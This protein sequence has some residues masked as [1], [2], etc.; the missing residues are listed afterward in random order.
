MST[1]QETTVSSTSSRGRRGRYSRPR[2]RGG[3]VDSEE[4]PQ[5]SN[6]LPAATESILPSRSPP[7]RPGQ[8]V[9]PA[10]R[11]GETRRGVQGQLET[12]RQVASG[13]VRHN[14][15]SGRGA[16]GGRR[17]GA[18]HNVP[19]RTFGG[20]L[21]NGQPSTL[22][23]SSNPSLQPDAPEFMPGQPLVVRNE[24]AVTAQRPRRMSKSAAPDISTRIHEDVANR[25]YECAICT[26]EVLR[27]SKIW[28]CKTCWT[29]FHLSCVTKWS[30]NEGST[31]QRQQE[32]GIPL[33]RQWRC[34]GCNLPKDD[35]PGAYTCWCGKEVDPKPVYGSRPH[36]C[37]QT[38]G[39][40]R[41]SR[42]NP[43]QK[44]PHPCE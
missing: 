31:Q 14:S 9:M 33:P 29:V 44:C 17:G 4:A 36:S 21:T 13:D 7:A 37:G 39:K 28:S 22:L 24:M 32:E 35:L 34:P 30:K 2:R 25:L 20:Q 43:D 3:V 8:R 38:C 40:M 12:Q 26:S 23:S 19:Q 5:H 18:V 10:Q 15:R 16:R 42:K 41:T 6:A 27:N 1:I 11:E